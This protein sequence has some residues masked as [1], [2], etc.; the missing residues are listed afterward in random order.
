[1]L[2]H[3]YVEEK[4]LVS[5]LATKR[6]VGVTPQVNLCEN[7]TVHRLPSVNKAAYSGFEA[8]RRRDQKSKTWGISGSKKLNNG[9]MFVWPLKSLFWISGVACSGF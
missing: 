2:V 4:D 1:M 3:K 6:L 7:V 5:M 9:S 8:Q